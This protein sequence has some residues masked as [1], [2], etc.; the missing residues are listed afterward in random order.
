MSILASVVICIS[1]TD[2]WGTTNPQRDP[3]ENRRWRDCEE[4]TV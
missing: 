2:R 3:S 4:R 1:L